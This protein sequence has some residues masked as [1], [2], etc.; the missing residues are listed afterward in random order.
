MNAPAGSAARMAFRLAFRTESACTLAAV[1]EAAQTARSWLADQGLTEDELAAWEL[2]LV[3][4]C[5]NAVEHATEAGRARPVRIDVSCGETDVEARVTDHT[6]GFDLPASVG[7]PGVEDEGGRGLFLI[8]S[9]TDHMDYHRGRDANVLILRKS[10][11]LPSAPR[12]PDPLELQHRLAESE[13][14]LSDMADELSSSYEG[15]VAMFRYSALL[16]AGGDVREFARRL[17]N[18]LAQLTASDAVILRLLGPDGSLAP[19]LAWPEELGSNLAALAPAHRGRSVELAALR[20][21]EDAWFGGEHPL[22][23]DDPLGAIPGLGLGV[24]HAFGTADQMLGTLTLVRGPAASPFR[25]AQIS[26]LHTFVDF[27]GIQIVN[28]R[29]LDERTRALGM[30]R[31]LEIAARIQNSLL[32]IA[33]PPCPPFE[34]AASCLSA[35]EVGGDYYDAIPVAGQ[36]VLLVVADVMGKGVPA[37]LF[38]A[39]LRSTV[40]SMPALFEQPASLLAAVNRILCDDLAR[41]EMFVTAKACFL[42]TGRREIVSSSAGHWPLL[43]RLPGEASARPADESGLPLGIDPES[44]YPQTAVDLP[45]GATAILYT[46][47]VTEARDAAGRMFGEDRLAGLLATLAAEDRTARDLGDRLLANF[48]EFRAGAPPTDDQTFILVRHTL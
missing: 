43:V 33:L 15:L 19:F 18:D 42:H 45:P 35:R 22:G 38:A 8:Q 3:E 41:A 6:K 48:E 31:E 34:L 47:G 37:A 5:N 25:S 16:G 44:R 27:L 29:L 13:A 28:A 24:S 32:P 21:R 14:A 46:D 26:L 20:T 7:L 39:L 17:L 4:A 12:G 11:S 40:R 10:R 1:R 23:P 36:G 9:L 30:R 2:A